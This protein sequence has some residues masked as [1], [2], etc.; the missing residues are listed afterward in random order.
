MPYIVAPPKPDRTSVLPVSRR[1][2]LERS[3][4]AG[5]IAA[6]LNSARPFRPAFVY[7]RDAELFNSNAATGCCEEAR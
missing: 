1:V 7:C 6:G 3:V 2:L 5:V 4:S